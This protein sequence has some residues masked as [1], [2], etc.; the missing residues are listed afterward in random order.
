MWGF[1]SHRYE[2][3]LGK[4]RSFFFT[5]PQQ[6]EKPKPTFAERLAEKQSTKTHDDIKI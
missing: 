2:S 4:R 3:K 6:T 5:H 1:N